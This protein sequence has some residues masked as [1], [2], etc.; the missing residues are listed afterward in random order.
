LIENIIGTVLSPFQVGFQKTIDFMSHE[1]KR[2][3]FLKNMYRQYFELKEQHRKLKHQNYLLRKQ[4]AE[5]EFQARV[6]KTNLNFQGV[7]VIS[8]DNSIPF[9]SVFIN[10][11]S[12]NGIQKDMVLINEDGELVGR[13]VDPI[14][15][16]SAKVR[17]ITSSLGGLGV[18]IKKN[19]LE[20]FLT[21]NNQKYC[22]FKYLMEN[23]PVE[24]GDEVTTSGT[25]EIFPPYLPVGRVVEIEK[26]YL[27]QKIW[28]K[29]YFVG[30]SIKQLVVIRKAEEKI[31][32]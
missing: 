30:K 23:A 29:P 10:R 9:S 24:I 20:G 15:P 12:S 31:E 6:K 26:E 4:L 21:G 32:E 7:K 18:Y 11:G 3:V 14:T 28:V 8:V 2:Y 1:I 13:V 27:T 19:K 22:L 16:L 5:V 17:L 25:D